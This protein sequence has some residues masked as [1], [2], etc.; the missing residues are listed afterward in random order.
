MPINNQTI[1]YPYGTDDL[2]CKIEYDANLIL[3]LGRAR[4]GAVTSA[5]EWQIKKYTYDVSGN[6]TAWQFAGG[7][8][9]YTKVWD[10]RASY[11]Y[12]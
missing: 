4:P 6:V 11:T 9:D 7:T 10:D 1:A 5:P 8:N 12:S 2:Q 3:Y